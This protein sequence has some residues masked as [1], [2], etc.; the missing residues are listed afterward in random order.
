MEPVGKRPAPRNRE[1]ALRDF[2]RMACVVHSVHE[3]GSFGST[4]D[5]LRGLES[6]KGAKGGGV[7]VFSHDDH[8][9]AIHGCPMPGNECRCFAPRMW[10]STYLGPSIRRPLPYANGRLTEEHWQV[11]LKH[12]VSARGERALL[13][14]QLGRNQPGYRG[15]AHV[16]SSLREAKMLGDRDPGS[17]E[18]CITY[19]I[20][21][22]IA[23]GEHGSLVAE[24]MGP[25]D[26]KEKVSQLQYA[27]GLAMKIADDVISSLP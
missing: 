10:L 11:L 8:V 13:F 3:F 7:L 19:G 15:Q 24:Q 27:L 20:E 12:L 1:L 14:A 9:H 21:G 23:A 26:A 25:G 2:Q 16:L 5:S 22:E 6:S 4:L 17:R 18:R